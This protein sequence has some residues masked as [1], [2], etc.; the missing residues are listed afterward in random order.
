MSIIPAAGAFV[1]CLLWGTERST[2]LKKRAQLLSELKQMTI[3]FSV[4]ISCTAPPLDELILHC[5]G[6][7]G[8]LLRQKLERYPDVRSAWQEAVAQLSECR[9]CGSGETELL[10]QLGKDLGTCPANGQL[11]LLELYSEQ[12]SKLLEEA[13]RDTASKGKLFRSVGTLTGLG[14]AILIL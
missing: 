1:L 4:A 12:L 6:V 11:A 3:Q 7:F 8:Q 13:E 2:Q 10:M 5:G 9:F 14:A